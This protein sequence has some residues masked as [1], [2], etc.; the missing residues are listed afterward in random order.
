VPG[1]ELLGQLVTAGIPVKLVLG[2]VAAEAQLH[3][4]L[5]AIADATAALSPVAA[6]DR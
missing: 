5:G 4:E 3:L 1:A 2:R 6:L